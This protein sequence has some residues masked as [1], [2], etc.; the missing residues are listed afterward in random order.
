MIGKKLIPNQLRKI[1]LENFR[2][3]FCKENEINIFKK[4][5]TNLLAKQSLN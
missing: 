5:K 4:I 3:Y 2:K 1:L